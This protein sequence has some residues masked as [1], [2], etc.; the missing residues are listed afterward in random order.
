[1]L[2]RLPDRS[3]RSHTDS[4]GILILSKSRKMLFIRFCTTTVDL[5]TNE[6]VTLAQKPGVRSGDTM[7]SDL[8]NRTFRSWLHLPK[9][10]DSRSAKA[11]FNFLN[12]FSDVFCP[13]SSS[14]CCNVSV[15]IREGNFAN[16]L[17][18]PQFAGCTLVL[19][20]CAEWPVC[21]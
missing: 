11:F 3:T 13:S 4:D 20:T 14:G 8:D 10:F 17:P 6:D 5:I 1:M 9:Q 7:L 21:Y 16:I 12:Y 19:S 2:I 15:Y 18:P